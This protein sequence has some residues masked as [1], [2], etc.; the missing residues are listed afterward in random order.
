[1]ITKAILVF[2]TTADVQWGTVP[3]WITAVGAV[4]LGI[5][6]ALLG[7]RQ[8][9]REGFLPKVEAWLDSRRAVVG[10]RVWNVGRG[11]GYVEKV[12]IIQERRKVVAETWPLTFPGVGDNGTWSR[13]P[14]A[15]ADS[16]VLYVRR[17]DG[18]VF[19]SE[20]LKVQVWLG[21]SGRIT[22]PIR[23]DIHSYDGLTAQ[24]PNS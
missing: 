13:Q 18:Q 12:L 1:V 4:V 5:G 11:K 23:Q 24:L 2:T 6:V 8:W 10:M 22:K 9:R 16:V 21:A 3:D 20:H 7:V 15:G 17:A 19:P 14:L